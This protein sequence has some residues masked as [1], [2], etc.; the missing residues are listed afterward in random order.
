MRAAHGIALGAALALG[1]IVFGVRWWLFRPSENRVVGEDQVR[2]PGMLE[3]ST[4][5]RTYEGPAGHG[6]NVPSPFPQVDKTAKLEVRDLEVGDGDLAKP[7]SLVHL[8]FSVSVGKEAGGTKVSE[9]TTPAPF[10]LGANQLLPGI[11][12]GV[13][14][15][16]VGGKRELRV[17]PVLGYGGRG[18][19]PTIPPASWLF[20]TVE[21][22][23][24]E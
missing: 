19:P 18:L 12:Q 3:P 10:K 1:A 7:A 13:Q 15:M 21:L 16:K 9:S 22:A 23:S 2:A 17:P 20:V 14:G 6:Y 24:V 11:D 5:P 8:I 4:T